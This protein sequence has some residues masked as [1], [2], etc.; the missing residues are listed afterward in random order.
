MANLQALLGGKRRVEPSAHILTQLLPPSVTYRGPSSNANTLEKE[1]RAFY[2]MYVAM[3]RGH[4][5][6][7]RTYPAMQTCLMKLA[8]RFRAYA[9]V[10]LVIHFPDYLAAHKERYGSKLKPT[11]LISRYSLKIYNNYMTQKRVTK[12]TLTRSEE[13]LYTQQVVEDLVQLRGESKDA[14]RQLLRDLDLL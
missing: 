13:H 14:V 8:K 1:A 4:G 2:H 12:F 6:W 9:Q 10:G 11:H 7:L 3:E 5:H